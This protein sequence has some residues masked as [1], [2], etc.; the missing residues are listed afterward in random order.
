MGIQICSNKGAGPFSAPIKGKI[1]KSLINFQN[2]LLVN[3]WL[4]CIDI[5][6]GTSLEPGDTRLK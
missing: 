5:W 6:N 4:E 3:H 2:L 1:M